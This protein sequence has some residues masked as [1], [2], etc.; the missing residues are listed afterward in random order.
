MT[1]DLAETVRAYVGNRGARS[2]LYERSDSKRRT[3]SCVLAAEDLFGGLSFAIG[4]DS[5]TTDHFVDST[6]TF[7]WNLATSFYWTT[8]H[9]TIPIGFELLPILSG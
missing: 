5:Y 1:L 9:L 2:P 3:S 6:K 8:C 4:E 7:P